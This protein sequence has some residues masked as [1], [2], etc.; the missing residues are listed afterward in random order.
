MGVERGSGPQPS[1]AVEPQRNQYRLYFL[2]GLGGRI[3]HSHEFE[4]ESDERAL[5]L[6]QGWREG[7]R[8]ELWTGARKLGAWPADETPSA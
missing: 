8:T 4:A 1:P 2:Q 5:G 3:L 6:A 7:R